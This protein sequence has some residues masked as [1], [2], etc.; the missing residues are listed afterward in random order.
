M[1]NKKIKSEKVI[2]DKKTNPMVIVLA[3]LAFVVLLGAPIFI[4]AKLDILSVGKFGGK[5]GSDL[6][7]AEFTEVSQEELEITEQWGVTPLNQ[8][9]VVLHDDEK[10]DLA[11]E[12][13]KDLDGEIVGEMEYLNLYQISFDALDEKKFNEKLEEIQEMDGVET[14]FPNVINLSKEIKGTACSPLNDPVFESEEN[15]R[16]YEMIGM[17]EA[18]KIIKASKVNLSNVKVGVLDEA[19]YT[20]SKEVGGKV[21]VSGDTTDNP[22]KNDAGDVV[23]D[24]LNH[25][26]FVTHVIGADP[27]NAG[28]TGIASILGDK[29]TIDVKNLYDGVPL[30]NPDGNDPNN[31]TVG[32]KP[33]GASVTIKG[34]VYLQKQVESGAKVIN[35]SYGPDRP[36]ASNQWINAAYKK[37]FEKM[38]KDH[39]DVIFVAAA[40]NEA[41]VNGAITSNNY[42]PAGIPL[43]NVIT[44][45]ALNNDG[46]KA[47]FSNFASGD[48]E[49]T[50]SA[51]GVKVVMGVDDEGKP[52]TSSGTSF[53]TPQVTATIALLQSINPKLTA[54]QIKEYIVKSSQPGTINKDQSTL[55]PEGMGAGLLRIDNAV[56][57]VINDMRKK[58]NKDPF[59]MESL[60]NMSTVDLTATGG[61]KNFKVKAVLPEISEGSATVKITVN[62][63]HVMKGKSSKTVGPNEEAIWELEIEDSSVFVKVVRDDTDTCAYMTL[64]QGNYEGKWDT[65]LTITEDSLMPLIAKMIGDAFQDTAEEMGCEVTESENGEQKID[66]IG[67]TNESYLNIV[68]LDEEGTSYSLNS[69]SKVYVEEGFDFSQLAKNMQGILQDDGSVLFVIE[70]SE[71][72]MTM[73]FEITTLLVDEKT[74]TGTY[75]L[76][77]IGTSEGVVFTKDNYI[78]GT[79]EGTKLE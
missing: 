34:L 7:K 47:S 58:E 63:Q 43:P 18:W 32:V 54:E 76:Y 17:T 14:A 59:T 1:K 66:T 41:K 22:E 35:C 25:G 4:L 15:S 6:G 72:G 2:K 61:G 12:I 50:L 8:I 29:L 21:K 62:G 48:G 52:V 36:K 3:V 28:T 65:L 26:T 39:P 5:S 74:I 37:F 40:G 79:L 10:V 78:A 60:L 13:A 24:G 70:Q 77:I 11:K 75:K 71:D 53:A 68:K 20:G 46:T 19:V 51:P 57:A 31:V 67:M 27:D 44:V 38:A 33:S 16:A 55:I 49:V 64:N 45:G 30:A 23:D 42:Y 73:H 9:I 56:L 69:E